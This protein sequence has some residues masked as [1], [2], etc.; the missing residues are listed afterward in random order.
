[1]NNNQLTMNNAQEELLLNLAAG[2]LMADE[3]GM[4]VSSPTKRPAG[5]LPDRT[6][7][8]N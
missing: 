8:A 5:R 3:I 1:M 2:W 6:C 4:R 7:C